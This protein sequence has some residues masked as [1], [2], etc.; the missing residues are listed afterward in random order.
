MFRKNVSIV[1]FVTALY[2]DL[3]DQLAHAFY[4]H[5]IKNSM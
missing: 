4:T 1:Q 5:R 2:I 3:T